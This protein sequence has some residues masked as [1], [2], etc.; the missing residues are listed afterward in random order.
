MANYIKNNIKYGLSIILTTN[1]NHHCSFGAIVHIVS[2]TVCE[3]PTCRGRAFSPCLSVHHHL[4][5]KISSRMEIEDYL[6]KRKNKK[7]TTT[8]TGGGAGAVPHYSWES[9]SKQ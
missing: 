8:T 1:F 9:D 3:L 2:A 7:C 6:K 5:R 4:S